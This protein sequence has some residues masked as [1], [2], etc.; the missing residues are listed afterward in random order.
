MSFD[1]FFFWFAVTL[2]VTYGMTASMLL[3]PVR[4]ALGMR[5][6]VLVGLIYCPV[7][8]G[9]WVAIATAMLFPHDGWWRF[10]LSPACFTTLL[11][12]IKLVRDDFL[13]TPT[14]QIEQETA[15]R[16]R[17]IRQGL[18]PPEETEE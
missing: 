8:F 2:T 11:L 3:M 16:I 15:M 1:G 10:V 12:L 13:T 18:G 9:F 6:P 17:M 7:C 5:A 4:V 14:M